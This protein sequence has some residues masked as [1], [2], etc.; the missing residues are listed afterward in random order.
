VTRPLRALLA[1]WV[2]EK[3][4]PR[5]V[6]FLRALG[7]AL[8]VLLLSQAATGMLLALCYVPSPDH[9][10]DSIRYID[11][12]VAG[13]AL[14]R[15]LHHWGA[16]A[17]IVLA[18]L[19]LARV[20]FTGAY[21]RPR[22]LLWVL[23]VAIFG[24]LIGFGFTGY[25]LPWDMKAYWATEVGL[26]IVETVPRVGPD[27]ADLL[28]G[29]PEL[30]APTLT[31]MFALHVLILPA[32]LLPLAGLHLLL[33]HKLG[34]TPP[35]ARVGEPEEKSE[36]FFPDHVFRELLVAALALAA[37]VALWWRFGTPLEAAASRDAG[38]YEPRPEWYFLGLFELLK[39][40]PGD[41]KVVATVFI[42]GG[43]S[44]LALLLP[45]IDLGRERAPRRRPIAVG[46]GV[47]LI[48]AIGVLTYQGWEDAPVNV[49]PPA[50]RVPVGDGS[51]EPPPSPPF[52]APGANDGT[53][54]GTGEAPSAADAEHLAAGEALMREYE[55][56]A[57]HTYRGAGD[58]TAAGAPELVGLAKERDAAWLEL[59]LLDPKK[60]KPDID[61]PSAEYLEMSDEDRRK[62]AAWLVVIGRE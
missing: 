50:P 52:S 25:L 2:F 22:A 7:T 58:D 23:G 13:G 4:V 40:F 15:G 16:S 45:W 35:G 54:A 30:G 28:R 18:A 12:D 62:L 34:I 37:V 8:L 29:G 20:Y 24:V 43:L 48:G 1:E 21:K 32:L 55:C 49:R 59:F 6:G 51:Y 39:H 53:G 19:H 11:E 9:A 10:Y 60:S 42:P 5:G 33:V 46:L 17:I 3:K 26:E 47:L 14:L 56:T 41:S 27:V 38:D 44:L 31:R 61:M 57:C 36:P